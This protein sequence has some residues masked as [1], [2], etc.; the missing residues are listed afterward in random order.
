MSSAAISSPKIDPSGNGAERGTLGQLNLILYNLGY[1]VE[2]H[3][4]MWPIK[5]A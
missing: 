5:V 1:N 4:Q 3:Q 2:I